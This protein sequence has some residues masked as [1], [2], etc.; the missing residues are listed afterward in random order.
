[1][2]EEPRFQIDDVAYYVDDLR[3]ERLVI[4][5]IE[6]NIILNRG[7]LWFYNDELSDKWYSTAE[8]ALDVVQER[9]KQFLEKLERGNRQRLSMDNETESEG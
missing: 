7:T 9:C 4:L 1:M 6:K 2:S 5:K 3:I 8:E